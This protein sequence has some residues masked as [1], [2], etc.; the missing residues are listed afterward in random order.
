[1]TDEEKKKMRG[2]CWKCEHKEAVPY[3]CHIKCN[4]PDPDMT[5]NQH[6]INKGWFIYPLLF[7]P[8]WKTKLCVN[9]SE[10]GG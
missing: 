9:F 4:N 8:V 7:D 10:G 2:E 5:G 3:N 6:G 1:M